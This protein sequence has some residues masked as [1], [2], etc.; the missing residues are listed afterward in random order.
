MSPRLA[1]LSPLLLTLVG[2]EE[3]LE[4][5]DTS[6][7]AFG[8]ASQQG[9]PSSS[10]IIVRFTH[11]ELGFTFIWDYD[12]ELQLLVH[13][14]VHDGIDGLTPD[15]AV[16]QCITPAETH[17]W[18]FKFGFLPPGDIHLN[19]RAKE[20]FARVYDARTVPVD[21]ALGFPIPTCALLTSDLV[22]AEGVVSLRTVDLEGAGGP[23]LNSYGFQANG[24]LVTPEGVAVHLHESFR[25]RYNGSTV[26]VLHKTLSLKPDPRF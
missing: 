24:R 9:P 21:P 25:E 3:P 1:L 2:C 8:L 13:Y 26:T 20:M 7:P 16:E 5:T 17:E 4:T 10:G 14:S 22:I 19:T 11:E 18:S 12:P 23:G 15:F 6:R